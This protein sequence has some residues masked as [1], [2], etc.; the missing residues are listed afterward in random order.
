MENVVVAVFPVES[1]A[2]QAFSRIKDGTTEL[3]GYLVSQMA[4][5]K[6]MGNNVQLED[7]FDTGMK[8]SDDTI[9]GGLI[10]ALIGIL[11]RPLGYSVRRRHRYFNWQL[12]RFRRY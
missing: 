12:H 8:T 10:G 9:S 11:G 6:K 3:S 2:Y 7:E 5:V 4:I 1:E